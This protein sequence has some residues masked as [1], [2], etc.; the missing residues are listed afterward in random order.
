MK[1]LQA[2]EIT[3]TAAATVKAP[4]TIIAAKIALTPTSSWNNKHC[5][6][7]VKTST[8]T[9]TDAT[10]TRSRNNNHFSS[11][12]RFNGSG[13]GSV[14]RAVASNIRDPRFKIGEIILNICL[15]STVLKGQ[16][17][18][19]RARECPIK[20]VKASPT[21]TT[22]SVA[23]KSTIYIQIVNRNVKSRIKYSTRRGVIFRDKSSTLFCSRLIYFFQIKINFLPT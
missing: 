15:L 1:H 16:N 22:T 23:T 9:A 6:S 17:E 12:K 18:I 11:S 21:L 14:G 3:T 4:T 19:K 7:N 10:P 2:E 20:T 5:T 13:C 8:T